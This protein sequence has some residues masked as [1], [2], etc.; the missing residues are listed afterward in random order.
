MVVVGSF[1][2]LWNR[3]RALIII[4]WRVCV[5][6]ATSGEEEEEEE[7]KGRRRRLIYVPYEKRNTFPLLSWEICISMKESKEIG[8]KIYKRREANI[9]RSIWLQQERKNDDDNATT[10]F[11]LPKVSETLNNTSFFFLSLIYK[12][13]LSRERERERE[14]RK[15]S[16]FL[17]RPRCVVRLMTC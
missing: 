9:F 7:K 3:S 11:R 15:S 16:D 2:T 8:R 17:P 14:K 1:I 5:C 10:L 12:Q 6:V 4:R 13:C